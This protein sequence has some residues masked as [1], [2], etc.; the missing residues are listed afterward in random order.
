MLPFC[1]LYLFKN[2]VARHV[3]ILYLFSNEIC[4]NIK[5]LQLFTFFRSA[6]SSLEVLLRIHYIKIILLIYIRRTQLRSFHII[7]SKMGRK[8]KKSSKIT[9][10][11]KNH[12]ESLPRELV[13]V[14]VERVASYSLK[15]LLRVKLRYLLNNFRFLIRFLDHLI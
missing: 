8:N 15:D 5:Y 7:I 2:Y 6:S 14:I 13:T 10:R 1:L 11:K 9:L 3:L 4:C 12:V